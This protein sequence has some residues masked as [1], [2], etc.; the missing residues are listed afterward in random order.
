MFRKMILPAALA[1]MTTAAVAQTAGTTTAEPLDPAVAEAQI[2]MPD[3]D[4]SNLTEAQ[5]DRLNVIMFSGPEDPLDKV[6]QIEAML[7]E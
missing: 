6:S 1:L 2:L 4:F 7:A 5:I 3:A